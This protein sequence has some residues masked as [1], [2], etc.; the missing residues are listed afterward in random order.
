MKWIRVNTEYI[1]NGLRVHFAPVRRVWNE[2]MARPCTHALCVGELDCCR[3][4]ENG[5]TSFAMEIYRSFI[6]SQNNSKLLQFGYDNVS[7]PPRVSRE[8]SI[9]NQSINR[10]CVE[11]MIPIDCHK[12]FDE[13]KGSV[14]YVE[15]VKIEFVISS[16]HV[17]RHHRWMQEEKIKEKKW[18]HKMCGSRWTHWSHRFVSSFNSII[19]SFVRS[20]SMKFV[21]F[22]FSS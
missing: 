16:S 18:L 19:F 12:S 10:W 22:I 7:P 13:V 5:K 21:H 4:F 14:I 8:L 11:K 6:R 1:S 20:F 9:H 15:L 2:R 17:Y 3:M